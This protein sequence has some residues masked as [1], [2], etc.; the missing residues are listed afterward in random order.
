[1]IPL[2]NHADMV[3]LSVNLA[4]TKMTSVEE[5]MEKLNLRDKIPLAYVLNM[6]SSAETYSYYSDYFILPQARQKAS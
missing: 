1:M 2:A 6:D 4:T 5:T 3:I